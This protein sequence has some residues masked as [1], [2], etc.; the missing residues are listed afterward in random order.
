MT[1]TII[2]CSIQTYKHTNIYIYLNIHTLSGYCIRLW[3]RPARNIK[4]IENKATRNKLEI[5]I[6]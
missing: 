3:K 4:N 1:I 2:N 6:N 5:K